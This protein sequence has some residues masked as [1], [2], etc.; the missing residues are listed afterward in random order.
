VYPE[1]LETTLERD[2][3]I[4]EAGIFELEMKPVCVVS[5]DEKA[6]AEA[7]RQALK[8]YNKTVSAHNQINRFAIV[9]ELPKTPLGKL[10]LQQLPEV[11]ERHEV[12]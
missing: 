7:V 3:R 12:K 9:D 1:E 2:S 8:I 4:K 10:A 11:F 6:P 5:S